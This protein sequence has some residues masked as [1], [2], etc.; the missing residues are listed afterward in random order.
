MNELAK[1]I[2][3]VID[4]SLIP[5]ENMEPIWGDVSKILKRATK[6]S[7]GRMS[8]VDIHNNLIDETSQLWIVFNTETLKVIGCTITHFQEY[9]TGLKMLNINILAGKSMEKWAK[10]GLELLY[11]WAKDNHCDGIE[12]ISRPGFWHW[13]K[14]R[15]SWKKTNVFYEVKFSEE[16]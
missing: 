11:S 14:H 3:P 4:I 6:R 8:V 10:E 12:F 5:P 13:V 7:Y 1:E 15:K 2:K 16:E 9:P